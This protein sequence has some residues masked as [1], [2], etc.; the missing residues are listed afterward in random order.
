MN[1][2]DNNL[3]M[4][5]VGLFPE[6][7]IKVDTE[8][9]DKVGLCI[10]VNVDDKKIKFKLPEIDPINKIMFPNTD[11]SMEFNQVIVDEIRNQLNQNKDDE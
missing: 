11:W 4:L 9:H 8:I 10:A 5:L 1:K 6:N 7:K 3:E 2:E